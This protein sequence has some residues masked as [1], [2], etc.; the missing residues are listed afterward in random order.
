MLFMGFSFFVLVSSYTD[1]SISNLP[2]IAGISIFSG[3]MGLIA[4][5]APAGIGVREGLII[6]LLSKIYPVEVAT[7]IAV[8]QRIWV[9]AADGGLFLWVIGY[10]LKEN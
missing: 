6:L 4:I 2:I 5:F 9:L 10:R 7:V 8:L 3:V 1:V